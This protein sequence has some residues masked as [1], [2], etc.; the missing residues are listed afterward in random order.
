MRREMQIIFQDPYASLNPRFTI[1]QIIEE[2][3]KRIDQYI[4]AHRQDILEDL[5]SLVRIPSV[6]REGEGG[7][8]FG[9]Q[10][11]RALELALELADQRGFYTNNHGDWYGT[12]FYAPSQEG[13][14]LI[15]IFSHLDVVEAG[16]GWL[17]DPFEPTEK[18]GFLI[19]RGA[20][21]NKSGAVI[22][23]YTMQALKE[24]D[25]PIKSN[26]M[27]YFGTNE[28]KGMK[29]AERFAEEHLM[30]DYSIVP[31][32]FFPVCCGEKGHLKMWLQSKVGFQ[33]IVRFQSGTADNVIPSQA[34]ADVC[35]CEG[36]YQ[37]ALELAGGRDGIELARNGDVMTV[38]ALGTGGH[39][40]MPQ[41]KVN[42]I[43]VLTD[44]LK[45]LEGLEEPD[46]G[47]CAALAQFTADHEGRALGIDWADEPSGALVC[48]A[49]RA[50]M[51]GPIPE[52]LFSS[53]YPVT[54]CRERIE[55]AL[56]NT[57]MEKGFELKESVNSAP[58]YIAREDP[59]VRCL[60]DVYRQA[61]GRDRESYVIDG[62]TYAR[63]LQRAVG[64][65]G[66]NGVRADFLPEGHGSVH[67]PDE[68][69][70][71]DGILEAIKIYILSVI[72]LDD[73]IQREHGH[74]TRTE[75]P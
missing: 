48:S 49:V 52:V 42:A 38:T 64:F 39:S 61:T 60:M 37:R 75:G 22:G 24:L 12:A 21:D 1:S 18:D 65:G 11:A 67:Q 66:G 4:A 57:I 7:K 30:P 71:I 44:F 14:S 10:C 23:L 29:D 9:S 69:R 35:R 25:I 31:D 50:G 27:L 5:K 2:L 59:F 68:A 70:H 55:A 16:E 20:G 51:D 73:M 3:I 40:A 45:G 26:V 15:G 72:A 41:G 8:P 74:K 28:E 32:L 62:G 36:L 63:K 53:R 6:S 17:Y 56:L 43:A 19:G 34:E 33:Q 47:I 46:R 54:D 13:E 58:M